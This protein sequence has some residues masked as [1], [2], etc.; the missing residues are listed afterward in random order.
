MIKIGVIAQVESEDELVQDFKRLKD[1]KISS[2]SGG[3]VEETAETAGDMELI[4]SSDAIYVD[5]LKVPEVEALKSYLRLSKDV[6]IKKPFVTSL[7]GIQQLINFQQEANCIVQLYSPCLFHPAILKVKEDLEAPLL[8]DMEIV[9]EDEKELEMELL[10][11]LLFLSG[12]A[13]SDFRKIEVFGLKGEKQSLIN[14]HVQYI[15]GSIGQLKVFTTKNRP[16][17]CK[18]DIH[19]KESAPISVEIKTDSKE[20]RDSKINALSHFANAIN[21]KGAIILSLTDLHQAI[22]ALIEVKEKL[23]YPNIQL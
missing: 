1:F 22:R 18:L 16:A 14:L 21:Q 7:R 15:S 2:S 8:F 3:N 12:I 4:H 17:C 6:F 13:K 23:K 9:L 10:K 20:E 11:T 19:Q 5:Q